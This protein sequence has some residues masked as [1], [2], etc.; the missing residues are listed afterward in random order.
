MA[1]RGIRDQIAVIGMGCTKFGERWD[2]GVDDLLTDAATEAAASAGLPIHD[3]DA[4]WL[5]TMTSGVC[6][7]TLSR[8]LKIDY[9][10]VTRVENYCATGSEAFRNACY[11]VASGAYDTAM[12]IGVEKLKDTGYSGLTGIRPVGDGT[13]PGLSSPA[14][15]SFLAPSYGRKYG[16]DAAQ[17]KEVMSRIAFKNHQNG[18][19]NPRAQFQKEVSMETIAKAPLVAG[20]LGVFD[21]SGVSDGSAAAIICRAEDAHKYCDNPLY[22]KALSFVAGPA[23]GPIDPDYDY[24]TFVEVVRSAE[25]AY[26]QAGITDPRRQLAM[27]EVHD[28]FT[29]TELVLMEDLGFAERGTAWKEVLAGT[30]DRDGELPVNP[31][32]GLK[33]FGHPIGASG[34]RMLFEC[35]LQLRGEAPADR[36][37]STV[38]PGRTMGLTHNLGGAPGEG[39]SFVG[40][41]GTERD[42]DAYAA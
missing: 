19:R 30:F 12:A 39:V 29:P 21:C 31:D 24:T 40:V 27:A 3:I 6:G 32:G 9:K 15:F 4:F 1:S 8:P 23:A 10:P 14:A 38:G 36:Q 16:V 20:E 33:S 41:V 18:A 26:R 25:D 42:A 35:W 17:M 7:T 28:C 11:G 2:T 22:V 5:G 34:L 37:I 13:D